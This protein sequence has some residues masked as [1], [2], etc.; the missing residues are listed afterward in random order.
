MG[1]L[2][3]QCNQKDNPCELK[4]NLFIKKLIEKKEKNDID[5]IN[6]KAKAG[7]ANTN[8]FEDKEDESKDKIFQF[9]FKNKV[10]LIQRNFLDYLK[11][12]SS[13][14]NNNQSIKTVDFTEQVKNKVFK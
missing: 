5:I 9:Y 13:N 3:C 8:V 7:K 14:R 12:K 4:V 6:Q 11:I 10:K 2:I 1:N